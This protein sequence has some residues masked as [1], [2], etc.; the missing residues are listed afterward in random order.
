M[1]FADFG[2]LG[3]SMKQA[4]Q[5]SPEELRAIVRTFPSWDFESFVRRSMFGGG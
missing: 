3:K 2:V 4:L 1:S 5:P